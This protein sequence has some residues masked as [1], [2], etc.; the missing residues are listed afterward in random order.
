MPHSKQKLLADIQ[1]AIEQIREITRNS[2][3]AN[4][5][6]DTTVRLAV[7]RLLINIGEAVSQ[8]VRAYPETADRIT[9]C[10]R[11]INLRHRLIHGYSDVSNAV[12]WDIVQTKLDRLFEEAQYILTD[13]Q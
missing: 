1:I 9:E 5:E 7:E 10:N 2:A 11:I 8:L 4:Y 13:R 12:I 3:R 6:K